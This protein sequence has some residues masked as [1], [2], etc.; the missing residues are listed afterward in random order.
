[1][2]GAA[3]AGLL[4][5]SGL[6]VGQEYVRAMRTDGEFEPAWSPVITALARYL[7]ASRA[8]A[9]VFGDWG[10]HN[11]V[12]AL[13]SWS[14]RARLS[15][16][17]WALRSADKPE[18]GQQIL[19]ESFAGKRVLVALHPPGGDGIPGARERFERWARTYRL[20]PRLQRTFTSPRG[21]VIYEVYAV[22]GRSRS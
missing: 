3:A 9:I 6:N 2:I 10:M 15:D 22:D 18:A 1:V 20:T 12:Y 17:W 16:L 7:D 11:Q 4:I 5:G 8:D 14:T 13:G 19:R 21:R